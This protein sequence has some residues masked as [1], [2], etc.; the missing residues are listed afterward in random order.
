MI[1]VAFWAAAQAAV[2]VYAP[3]P[4]PRPSAAPADVD[5][6]YPGRLAA[7]RQLLTLMRVDET[8]DMMFQPLTPIFAQAVVGMMQGNPDTRDA[9]QALFAHGEGGQGRF[10]AILSEEFMRSIRARYPQLKEAAAVEYAK[11]FTEAELRDLIAF[12]SSGTGSKALK[13]LP[14]LQK[15][16]AATGQE[17]GRAAGAEAGRRAFDRALR[18]MLPAGKPTRS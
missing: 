4:P 13:V 9:I 2:P 8:Y 18:E 6:S 3:P 14:E 1:T 15:R 7:G 11:S 5:A 12:Y 17:V 16:I 10:V